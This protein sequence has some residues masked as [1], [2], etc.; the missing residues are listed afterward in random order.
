MY[1]P[2]DVVELKVS[3]ANIGR[4]GDRFLVEQTKGA[5]DSDPGS[6]ARMFLFGVG[7]WMPVGDYLKLVRNGE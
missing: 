5:V 3:I 7:S 6:V 4:K 2:G 1:R